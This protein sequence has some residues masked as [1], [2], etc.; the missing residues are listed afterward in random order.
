MGIV[1]Q[2]IKSIW[3]ASSAGL[4]GSVEEAEAGWNRVAAMVKQKQRAESQERR[5]AAALRRV[6]R[7]QRM[8]RGTTVPA[9]TCGRCATQHRG[10][11]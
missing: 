1:E 8:T 3:M 4:Y 2:E 9:P 11:C 6:E 10:E 5:H 7:E